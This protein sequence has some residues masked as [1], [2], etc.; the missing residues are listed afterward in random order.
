MILPGG[1]PIR[2][3]GSQI[4]LQQLGE[5]HATGHSVRRLSYPSVNKY[6]DTVKTT[7]PELR[8][9]IK[10]KNAS[11]DCLFLGIFDK[12]S[13]KHIGNIK[14]EPMP[15]D[16]GRRRT[17]IGVLIGETSYWGR[18]VATEAIKLIVDWGFSHMPLDEIYA[19]FIAGHEK[20]KAAF[21]KNGFSHLKTE[22]RSD[23]PYRK[24]RKE[25]RLYLFRSEWEKKKQG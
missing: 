17:A 11:A 3:E 23:N 12:Q 25:E 13:G 19:G 4:C 8:Q 18:G 1:K 2:I 14:L 21:E 10:E 22:E 5:S 20:S 7:I 16:I 6:L 9:F 15:Y 24:K